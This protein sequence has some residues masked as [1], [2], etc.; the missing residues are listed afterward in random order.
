MHG[1]F[2][3]PLGDRTKRRIGA[4]L[5]GRFPVGKLPFDLGFDC[6]DV[7]VA[8]D[9]QQSAF[10]P[11]IA[12]VIGGDLGAVGGL[13]RLDRP[14]RKAFRQALTFE[15]EA[16]PCL[17]GA[18]LGGVAGPFLGED[19]ASFALDC[20][21]ADR[22]AIGRLAHQHQAGVEECAVVLRQIQHVH[23]LAER[24]VGVGVRT[25]REA[26][27][28]EDLD[29]LAFG[30]VLRTIEGHVLK[31]MREAALRV[32]LLQGAR[33]DAQAQCD[34]PR[35]LGVA[36]QRVA[37]AVGQNAVSHARI[38]GD[39]GPLVRPVRIL[40]LLASALCGVGRRRR[41]DDEQGDGE[42]GERAD[43]RDE[44]HVGSLTAVAAE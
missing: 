2:A 31:V 40:R 4:G 14:D 27:A 17:R 28:L 30:H 15:P 38:G 24:G 36:L 21:G 32:G 11:I 37:H 33:C 1:G 8:G 10:R 5:A 6:I 39:V 19:H 25:E 7:D 26:I 18:I 35:R 20:A 13:E 12:A 29:H 43:G 3:T 16:E 44:A 34:D 23:R 9:H 22:Q 42:R 41:A